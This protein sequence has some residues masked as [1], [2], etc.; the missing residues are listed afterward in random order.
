[1]R[2]LLPKEPEPQHAGAQQPGNV[3]TRFIKDKKF[4]PRLY[5]GQTSTYSV[6][7]DVF[8]PREGSAG[9]LE[10]STFLVDGL[11]EAELWDLGFEHYLPPGRQLK[12]RADV[13]TAEFLGQG[14]GFEPQPPPDRHGSFINWPSDDERILDIANHLSSLAKGVPHPE[15]SEAPRRPK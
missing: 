9:R 11:T 4:R 12:G 13:A 7:S 6:R 14:L 5:E 15:G 10:L 3:R 1:L 2:K 8:M